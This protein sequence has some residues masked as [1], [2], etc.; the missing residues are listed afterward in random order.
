[1][2]ASTKK[3]VLLLSKDLVIL[4]VI[5]SIITIPIMYFW[6]NEL[7]V[8][9]QHYSVQIGCVEV[10]VSLAV[11]MFLGLL[12]ILSQTMKAANANPVDNLRS[13]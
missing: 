4:M 2:G 5:A 13:E 1:M 6:I 9:V 11:I 7:L 8:S 12:T 3:L 10:L